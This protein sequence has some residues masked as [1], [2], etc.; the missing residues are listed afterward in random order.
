MS[1]RRVPTGIPEFDELIEGGFPENSMILVVGFPG[2]GKTTF[3][4]QFLY[5]GAEKFGARGVYVSFAETKQTFIRNMLRFGWDFERL[6]K[7]RR[8]AILDLSVTR[9]AGLQTN[10]NTMMETL[11]SLGAERLVI[12]SFTA[13]SMALKE[14]IDVRVMVHLLYKFLKKANC[15]SLVILDQPWG[16]TSIGQGIIEFLADGIIH[17]ETYFDENHTLRRRLRI[18]KMR[19]TKHSLSPHEY[20]INEN[21]F[22]I[23][24]KKRYTAE[25]LQRMTMPALWN[26]AK[27][28]GISRKGRK[29][30]LI[31]RILR[32]V[33]GSENTYTPT[34]RKRRKKRSSKSSRSKKT[35][36]S[37][38]GTKAE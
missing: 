13:I 11:T 19:G 35:E 38:K 25:S 4:G 32:A 24:K 21:G 30:E 33:E 3:S 26:I 7:E 12:D 23:L 15:V 6:E 1:F 18:L 5:T 14:D 22:V 10:L 9:E 17:L 34:T 36:K 29:Q 8:I 37:L 2:A 31:D 28:L 27:E 20:V 16:S